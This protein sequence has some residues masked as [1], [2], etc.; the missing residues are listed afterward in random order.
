[1]KPQAAIELITSILLFRGTPNRA[2]A[3]TPL[4]RGPAAIDKTAQTRANARVAQ[5]AHEM[6]VS[7]KFPAM[8]IFYL[9]TRLRWRE[10]DRLEITDPEAKPLGTGA[11]EELLRRLEGI[12]ERKTAVSVETQPDAIGIEANGAGR[13]ALG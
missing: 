1:M 2:R 3:S 7:G 11:V 13:L 6:A 5:T 4:T 12:A 8:T 10:T 9:K